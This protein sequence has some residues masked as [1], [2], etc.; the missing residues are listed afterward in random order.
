MN[1]QIN[2]DNNAFLQFVAK[3]KV[4]FYILL[5]I[6]TLIVIVGGIITAVNTHLGYILISIGLFFIGMSLIT[7]P[8]ATPSTNKFFGIAKG[9]AI[10]KVLGIL[11]IILG[12]V[13][14]I[15]Q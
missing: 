3:W 15:F 14:F 8:F 1:E 2:N 12:V 11:L 7:F 13:L 9:K 10:V 4:V 5:S 6:G